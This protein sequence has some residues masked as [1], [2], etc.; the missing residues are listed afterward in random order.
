MKQARPED[1]VHPDKLLK[2]LAG[3]G[4][5]PR[6]QRRDRMPTGVTVAL[7]VVGLVLVALMAKYAL[8]ILGI[9]LALVAIGIVLHVLGMRL[10]ESNILSPGWFLIVLLGLALF[11]YAYFVPAESVAGLGR[12]MPKWMVAGLE[13][14][15]S[16]GWGQRAL[17]GPAGGTGQP[18]AFEPAAPP[19]P[20]SAPSSRDSSGAL[21]MALTASSGASVNGQPVTF[22][23]RLS[24]IVEG[25]RTVRFYDGARLLG[26]AQ[27]RTEGRTRIAY[28]TVTGLGAGDHEIRAELT[29]TAGSSMALSPPLR[30]RVR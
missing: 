29:Y 5:S 14:S 8:D 25:Q 28:L 2:Y 18:T 27:V 23:A 3:P 20:S 11:A 13:W 12:Y 9:V 10:A 17:G 4:E 15:E 7:V 1:T 16:R 30:H 6:S 19:A 22:M 26:T 24:G 21:S